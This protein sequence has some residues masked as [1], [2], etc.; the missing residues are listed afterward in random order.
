[1]T[2]QYSCPVRITVVNSP[3]KIDCDPLLERE[4][5]FFHKYLIF[6]KKRG[7][8][9]NDRLASS[10]NKEFAPVGAVFYELT[11]IEKGGNHENDR[12]LYLKVF[13]FS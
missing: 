11:P 9:E 10:E 4:Q 8:N 1:M 3:L 6:T 7:K 5:C 12:L 13:L 2:S